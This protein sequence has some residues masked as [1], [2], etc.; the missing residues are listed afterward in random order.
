MILLASRALHC[1]FVMFLV[2]PICILLRFVFSLCGALARFGASE[3]G[4]GAPTS[5]SYSRK[6]PTESC[7]RL[8]K[9]PRGTMKL[10]N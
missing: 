10:Y 5:D 6:L 7:K 9:C 8:R 1:T 2:I 3:E 4:E